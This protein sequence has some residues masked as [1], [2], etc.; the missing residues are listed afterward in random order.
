MI[1]MYDYEVPWWRTVLFI[2]A[3]IFVLFLWWWYD[4]TRYSVI[5]IKT[6]SGYVEECVD[7]WTG[8]VWVRWSD[9]AGLF[10]TGWV[11]VTHESE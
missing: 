1:G 8:R 7:R 3:V 4:T 10:D 9:H 2:V 6:D 11:E 5:G